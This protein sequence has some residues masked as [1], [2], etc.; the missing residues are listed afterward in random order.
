MPRTTPSGGTAALAV[1]PPVSTA[2]FSDPDWIAPFAR[3]AEALGIESLILPEHVVLAVD[4]TSRYPYSKSGRVPL[5]HDCVIPDPLDT[6]AY[7]AGVTTTLGLATGLLVLPMHSPLVLAKR[8]ATVDR[9]SGG[10]L[11]LGVGLGWLRE[12][13]EAGGVDFARRGEQADETIDAI[14][15]L[16]HADPA[17]GA[18]FAGQHFSF[19]GVQSFPRPV[20]SGGVPIEVGGT[21]PAAI[22]RA[23]R[24]GDGWLSLGLRGDRLTEALGVLAA[25]AAAAGR[26]PSRIDVTLSGV[27]S[28]ATVDRATLVEAAALG[29]CRVV[30]NMAAATLDEARDELRQMAARAEL[31]PPG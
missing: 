13:L 30:V 12:E 9:L 7:V 11:R 23:A 10:R 25:E 5:P 4:Y 8:A 15:A 2:D 18:H 14:R 21:T 20:Q 1:I 26:D 28:T 3:E 24:R 29:A 31:A 6:L 19:A 22:R 27:T 17:R 16:W